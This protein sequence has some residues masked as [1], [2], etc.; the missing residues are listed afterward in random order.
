[1]LKNHSDRGLYFPVN[2]HMNRLGRRFTKKEDKSNDIMFFD[3][4]TK[5]GLKNVEYTKRDYEKL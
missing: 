3:K 2:L 1:M 4:L 5:G